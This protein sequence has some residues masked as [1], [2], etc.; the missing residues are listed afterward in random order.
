M[1]YVA[2]RVELP[3]IEITSIRKGDIDLR[4]ILCR[5]HRHLRILDY[6][7]GNYLEKRDMLDE[8]A[9]KEGLRKIFTLVEKSDG[10]SWRA[11]GFSREG[12]IP[13]FF[14]TADGYVMARMYDDNGPI[15]GGIPKPLV[16]KPQPPQRK[17]RRPEG[18]VTDIIRDPSGLA[19]AG[20]GA[21]TDYRIAPLGNTVLDPDLAVRIKVRKSLSWV[22][23]EV[24]ESFGHARVDLAAPRREL[25]EQGAVAHGLTVLMQDLLSRGVTSLFGICAVS[26]AWSSEVYTSLDFR[27]TGRLADH[28]WGSSG[29][30][31]VAIFHKRSGEPT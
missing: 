5:T 2:G 15:L 29:F 17:L 9:L 10:Q 12:V 8:M 1:A 19:Q 27:V 23:A 31:N 13:G 30:S 28:V 18:A 6:R 21:V 11:V 26:D 7:V 25:L 16:E 22:T 3:A 4:L 20:A 14:R 24:D